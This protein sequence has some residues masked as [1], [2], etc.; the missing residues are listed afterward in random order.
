MLRAAAGR[1][2]ALSGITMILFKVNVPLRGI[3]NI[4][5]YN[6]YIFSIFVYILDT[7]EDG[8]L[9][10][11]NDNCWSLA[12]GCASVLCAFAALREKY[13]REIRASGSF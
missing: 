7:I 5:E 8:A 10:G 11:N 4:T 12:F 1:A 2:A 13:A 9:K 3:K 6:E